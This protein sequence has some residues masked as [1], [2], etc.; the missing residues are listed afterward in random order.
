[1]LCLIPANAVT[2]KAFY[3]QE[4]RVALHMPAFVCRGQLQLLQSRVRLDCLVNPKDPLTSLCPGHTAVPRRLHVDSGWT[5][6][7]RTNWASFPIPIFPFEVC[8]SPVCASDP[9]E[10]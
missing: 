2:T 6:R 7:R 8:T 3:N 1:M 5:Q 4:G 9:Y 10:K